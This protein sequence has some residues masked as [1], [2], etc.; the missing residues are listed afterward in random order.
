MDYEWKR[1]GCYLSVRNC[2]DHQ[3]RMWKYS[4]Q[5]DREDALWCL[6]RRRNGILW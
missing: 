3:E 4:L 2:S 6:E 5:K 1:P